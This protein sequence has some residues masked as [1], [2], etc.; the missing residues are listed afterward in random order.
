MG[1]C[2]AKVCSAIPLSSVLKT[3]QD[4]VTY[5]YKPLES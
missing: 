5:V 3:T 1:N 2:V 4:I